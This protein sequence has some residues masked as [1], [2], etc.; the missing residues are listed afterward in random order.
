MTAGCLTLEQADSLRA[1]VDRL[2]RERNDARSD[3]MR[4]LEQQQ[5]M[6]LQSQPQPPQLQQQSSMRL[7][8][9][10]PATVTPGSQEDFRS[11]GGQPSG[12]TAAAGGPGAASANEVKAAAAIQK[13]KAK[14]ERLRKERDGAEKQAAAWLQSEKEKLRQEFAN[15]STTSSALPMA[16]T[17][18]TAPVSSSPEKV[19]AVSSDGDGRSFGDGKTRHRNVTSKSFSAEGGDS[20]GGGGGVGPRKNSGPVVASLKAESSRLKR[21]LDESKKEAKRWKD[22]ATANGSSGGGGMSGGFSRGVS[23]GGSTN[24]S[25]PAVNEYRDGDDE[26]RRCRLAQNKRDLG[27]DIVSQAGGAFFVSCILRS[28]RCVKI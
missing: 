23:S 9:P 7:P 15:A 8:A 5:Q 27:L 3:A 21:E 4:W 1:Q 25:S 11:G 22:R 13:L 16:G 26:V 24:T 20:G 18:A 10:S 28:H 19:A 14:V 2:R 12:A 6:Q 17:P